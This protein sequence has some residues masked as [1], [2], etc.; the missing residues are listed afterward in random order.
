MVRSN[1]GKKFQGHVPEFGV[2]NRACFLHHFDFSFTECFV[3]HFPGKHRMG[4]YKE[5]QQ[6]DKNNKGSFHP[7]PP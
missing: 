7:Y 3:P 1:V 6:A 4:I 5:K 2:N